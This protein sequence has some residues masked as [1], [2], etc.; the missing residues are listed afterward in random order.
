[1]SFISNWTTKLTYRIHIR[2]LYWGRTKLIIIL[3]S[4]KTC[5]V[6]FLYDYNDNVSRIQLPNW[7]FIW[8]TMH[9]FLDLEYL[10]CINKLV[11]FEISTDFK[12]TNESLYSIKFCLIS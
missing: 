5:L 1:M 10:K 8:L 12:E 6:I 4:W 7:Q 11:V 3:A 2:K 9:N